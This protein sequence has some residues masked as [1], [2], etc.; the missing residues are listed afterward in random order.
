MNIV[1]GSL[2]SVNGKELKVTG[3]Y[4]SGA[5]TRYVFN[6]GSEILDLHKMVESGIARVIFSTPTKKEY[7]VAKILQAIKNGEKAAD[8]DH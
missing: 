1:S 2:V 6:D 5:H 4:G 3:I 7:P 8:S